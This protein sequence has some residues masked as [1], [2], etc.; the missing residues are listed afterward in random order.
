MLF[1]ARH[2]LAPEFVVVSPRGP[3][4]VG[5]QLDSFTGE[6]FGARARG[7]F[8]VRDLP[9]GGRAPDAGEARAAWEHVTRFA[10]EAA[11]AYDADP[12]RV[13]VAGFSQGAMTALA[14]LLTAPDVFAGAAALGGRLLPEVT[15]HVA[16]PERLAGRAVLIA[17]GTGDPRVPVDE[18]RHARDTLSTLPLALTYA[19]VPARSHGVTGTMRARLAEWAASVAGVEHREARAVTPPA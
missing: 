10:G 3:V 2:H 5:D 8:H 7:W 19:E 1:T 18:A 15:P 11:A 16:A 13:L 14:A 6:R 12:A 9:G 4:A 17:H